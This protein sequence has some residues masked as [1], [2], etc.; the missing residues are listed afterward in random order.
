[1]ARLRKKNSEYP[2]GGIGLKP[3]E[4]DEY[5]KLLADVGLSSK[6]VVRSL[7]RSWI[8]NGGRLVLLKESMK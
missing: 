2:F 5:K 1:M 3:E 6:Q 8:R 7:V 4:E